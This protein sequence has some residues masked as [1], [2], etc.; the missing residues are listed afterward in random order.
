MIGRLRGPL[1]AKQPPLLVVEV[2]GIGFELEAPL[3]V[4]AALPEVGREV[5][6]LTHLALRDEQPV[7]YGFL[8]EAERRLFR[9]LIRV[10]GIGARTALAVLSAASPEEC[11]RWIEGADIA[12]LTRIPGIGRKTAERIVVELRE[13]AGDWLAGAARPEAAAAPGDALGEAVLA[14]RRLG[15]GP[16]EA[17]ELVRAVAGDGESTEAIV[18]KALRQA[19][20]G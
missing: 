11:A 20:R 8:R 9:E 10:S 3:A 4:F 6:L 2:L 5:Q 1:I 16:R 13:R 19:T 17:E 15:F 14:M 7:L 12:A 18:R